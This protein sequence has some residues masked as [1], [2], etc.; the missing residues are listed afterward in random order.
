MREFPTEPNGK[1]APGM[2]DLEK[3]CMARGMHMTDKRRAICRAFAD[4]GSHPDAEEVFQRTRLIEPRISR[5]TVYRTIK[6]MQEA[7]IL[8][9]QT[10]GER[11]GRF[12]E[13]APT[14]LNRR[15]ARALGYRLTDL[16]LELYG[17][18]SEPGDTAQ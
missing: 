5:G 13:A 7:G 2:T 15:I 8:S 16:K 11:R 17:I 6:A 9:R 10:F 1:V 18:L 3:K 12:E 14:S 4:C